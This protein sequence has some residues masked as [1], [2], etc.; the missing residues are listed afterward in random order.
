MTPGQFGIGLPSHSPW[1]RKRSCVLVNMF[2]SVV[3]GV[4]GIMLIVK[5]FFFDSRHLCQVAQPAAIGSAARHFL[6]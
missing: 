4:V 3:R 6:L 1:V 5:L 2:P